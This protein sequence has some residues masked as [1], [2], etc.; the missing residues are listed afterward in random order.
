MLVLPNKH[1]IWSFD[2][3][4]IKSLRTSEPQPIEYGVPQSIGP[5]LNTTQGLWGIEVTRYYWTE[6]YNPYEANG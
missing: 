6:I 2:P 4:I 3:I 5:D 1:D